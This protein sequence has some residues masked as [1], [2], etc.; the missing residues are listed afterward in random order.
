MGDPLGS[1]H[2][3]NREGEVGAQSGQY[4]AT[5]VERGRGV[6]LKCIFSSLPSTRPFGSSLAS[7]SIGTPKLSEKEVKALPGWVTH[8]KIAREFSKIKP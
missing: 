2:K 1:S 6:I 7:N 4:H 3:Q 8:W 5:V